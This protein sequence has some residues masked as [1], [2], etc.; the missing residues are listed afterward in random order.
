MKELAIYTASLSTMSDE[1]LNVFIAKAQQE[2]QH[3][4][5]Q[6]AQ[7]LWDKLNDV[8]NEIEER[9]YRVTSGWDTI[10]ADD[11]AVEDATEGDE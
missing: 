2:K 5:A 1:D 3:R 10:I 9:G 4:R 6:H 11:L 8:F 7:E